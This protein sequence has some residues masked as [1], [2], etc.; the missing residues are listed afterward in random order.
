M[1]D[2]RRIA[3]IVRISTRFNYKKKFPKRKKNVYKIHDENFFLKSFQDNFLG[4][5]SIT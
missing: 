2:E 5:T 1:I 4:N 3:H